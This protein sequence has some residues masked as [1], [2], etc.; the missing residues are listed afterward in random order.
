MGGVQIFFAVS[1][2]GNM[3]TLVLTLSELMGFYAIS[4]I[5]LIRK[6]LPPKYRCRGD[7][8]MRAQDC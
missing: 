1:G 5:L 4:T 6:Q 7:P 2:E 3:T 8:S